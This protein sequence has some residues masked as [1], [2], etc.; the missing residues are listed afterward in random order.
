MLQL[1]CIEETPWF[2]ADAF[3]GCFMGPHHVKFIRM[4]PLIADKPLD[5]VNILHPIPKERKPPLG[6]IIWPMH[7]IEK[8]QKDDKNGRRLQS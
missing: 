3:H 2:L 8:P 4:V 7:Q 1:F 6:R 5:L